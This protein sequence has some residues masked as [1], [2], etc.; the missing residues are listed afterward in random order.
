MNLPWDQETGK[1]LRAA[2]A[3]LAPADIAWFEAAHAPAFP[4]PTAAMERIFGELL[5]GDAEPA[6]NADLEPEAATPLRRHESRV[7]ERAP[8][9]SAAR[10]L[11][12]SAPARRI[13]R[14]PHARPPVSIRPLRPVARDDRSDRTPARDGRVTATAGSAAGRPPT[15]PG[16]VPDV[17]PEAAAHAGAG[18]PDERSMSLSPSVVE[19]RPGSNGLRRAQAATD[20]ATDMAIDKAADMATD[21]ATDMAIDRAAD[22]ATDTATDMAIDRAADRQ[23]SRGTAQA[24]DRQV[25]APGARAADPD[26]PSSRHAAAPG[27]RLVTGLSALNNLFRSV[28]ESQSDRHASEAARSSAP[29]E[30]ASLRDGEASADRHEMIRPDAAAR[31]TGPSADHAHEAAFGA[32]FDPGRQVEPRADAPRASGH[33]RIDAPFASFAGT[34]PTLPD[35][36]RED[37]LLDR[38]L[39]RFE[40]RLREHA[41]RHLGFTG[42]LT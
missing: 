39:D 29:G 19:H 1:A 24:A 16:A 18:T 41:I 12:S 25:I 36:T 40:E 35:P 23:A 6:A 9:E 28:I 32:P 14:D 27:T 30:Y 17:W 22:M 34:A 2:R 8:S 11:P 20:V 26:L 10:P 31:W 37:V 5:G 7:G 21:A 13:A 42:G 38:L 3:V 4:D 15:Q 33:A